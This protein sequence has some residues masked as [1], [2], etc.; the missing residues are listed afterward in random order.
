MLLA[1]ACRHWLRTRSTTPPAASDSLPE[2]I[3]PF[4]TL[5]HLRS[6]L[7]GATSVGEGERIAN[8]IAEL[9]KRCFSPQPNPPGG[10]EL[11]SILLAHS[12][13]L[14][15]GKPPEGSPRQSAAAL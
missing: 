13:K 2:V 3:T 6:A 12:S 10:A 7:D 11:R 14:L 15:A 5:A 8:A 4:T 9:E 1:A